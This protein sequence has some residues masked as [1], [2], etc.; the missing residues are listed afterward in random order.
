[1]L[2]ARLVSNEIETIQPLCN[3]ITVVQGYVA[4]VPLA[5]VEP[6]TLELEVLCSIL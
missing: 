4:S 6:A 1:M 2:A 5:G 3:Y